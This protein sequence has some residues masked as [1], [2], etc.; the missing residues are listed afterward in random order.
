MSDLSYLSIDQAHDL[1]VQKKITAV[2]LTQYHLE[3]IRQLDEVLELTLE[4]CE[5][6]ALAQAEKVDA[7][8]AAGE[9]IGLLEGIPYTAK[10]MFL[11]AGIK[12]TAASKILE[13]F[14]PPFSAT[15]IK[16]LDQAGAILIAKVNHDEFA[17]GTT[18]ENSAYRVT[19]NPW[20]TNRAPGGSSGGSAAAVAAD[21]G[22]FSIGTDTG[23]SIR[24]PA[25]FC[26]VTGLKPTYG[27]VSRYG[28]VAMASSLDTIGPVT[29]SAQD[30]AIVLAA[31]A[32]R[33]VADSTT[34]Q[35]D[36][37]D[38]VKGND[39]LAGKTVGVIK[40][41]ID[42][43]DDDNRQ[44]FDAAVARMKEAGAK[45][46][47]I[48]MP[49]I[50]YSLPCYYIVV[51]SEI[52]SNLSR[53]DGIRFGYSDE[54]ATDLQQTYLRSR[55]KGFGPEAKR[56]IMTGTYALSAGYY[57]AYYKKAMQV[58]TLIIEDFRRALD[59]VDF[60]V[61]PTSPT[62]AVKLGENAE[63]PVAMYLLDIMTV[64]INLAGV[65]SVSVPAGFVDNLP[66]GMQII[67]RQGD[68]GDV[69]RAARAFQQVTDWHAKRPQL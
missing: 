26:G 9:A 12:T 11:T 38:F 65:P 55:G 53:Y 49:N 28:V 21:V 51:P 45:V 62:P 32:G 19:R 6:S 50:S 30:A 4:I 63:D 46:R 52:S 68:D 69:L 39:S 60:L 43:L 7:K 66:V 34:I 47:E 3:R 44:V 48:D 13:K 14:E 42:G 31:I 18:T 15:V 24:Q 23:G 41:Y 61:G 40:Q 37:Y 64:A 27:L 29:R 36:D 10:D 2:E 56:R 25:A 22:I 57:D 33:D 35:I 67:G 8:I 17:H 16:K 54:T 20:D 58:R 5:S 59:E 1:L